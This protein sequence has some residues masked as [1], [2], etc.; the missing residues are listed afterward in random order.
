MRRVARAKS[1]KM[2]SYRVVTSGSKVSSCRAVRIAP[3][4]AIT[5]E[6]RSASGS[7]HLAGLVPSATLNPVKKLVALA[8]VMVGLA[9]AWHLTPLAE[10]ARTE[11]LRTHAEALRS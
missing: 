3:G 1:P 7:R 2:L 10:L 9:L 5:L 8:V 4:E 11:T 6:A